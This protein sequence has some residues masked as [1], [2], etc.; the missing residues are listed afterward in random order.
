MVK[1]P[2]RDEVLG[3][4][5]S[6]LRGTGGRRAHAE[7]PAGQTPLS[8]DEIG[9]IIEG[10]VY[11]GRPVMAAAEPL[12][13]AHDLGP[14]GA[15][16][17]S[18]V[19]RGVHA[20]MELAVALQIGRSLVTAELARLTEAGLIAALQEKRDQRRRRLTL[21]ASGQEALAAL[22]GSLWGIVTEGL[23]DYSPAEIRLFGE[24]LH[25]VWRPRSD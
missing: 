12:N 15:F 18:L 2:V 3:K 22:R 21:T 14:R 24:M 17:L 16:I 1:R 9:F 7:T 5:A 11:A 25:A 6:P 23:A 20:P 8:E 19:D 13:R 10:L 4:V